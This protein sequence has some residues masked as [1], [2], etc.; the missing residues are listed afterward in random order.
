LGFVKS[1]RFYLREKWGEIQQ[2]RNSTNAPQDSNADGI[3]VQKKSQEDEEECRM[4]KENYE[5]IMH[6]FEKRE[7]RLK[8]VKGDKTFTTQKENCEW[9]TQ[10]FEE[11]ESR[12]EYV[13]QKLDQLGTKL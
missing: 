13:M 1:W 3:M 2:M 10:R 9:I 7:S 12:L 6:T 11:M 8:S 4:K 5:S